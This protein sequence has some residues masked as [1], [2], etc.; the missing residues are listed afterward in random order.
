MAGMIENR[1]QLRTAYM[2][3]GLLKDSV[4]LEVNEPVK[5]LKRKIRLYN[6]RESMKPMIVKED[7]IDGYVSLEQLDGET[8]RLS[9]PEVEEWFRDN[10][11]IAI[12][13]SAYDCTG[14]AFTSWF[15]IVRRRG[16]WYA[17][18][19]ICFDV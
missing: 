17:Y 2:L 14:R 15:K 7:G 16:H 3:V 13:P 18:H 12:L 8:D 6:K 9:L 1:E 4:S 10:R 11:E 5:E 19:R